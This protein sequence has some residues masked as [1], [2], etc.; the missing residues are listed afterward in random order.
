MTVDHPY[1]LQVKTLDVPAGQAGDRDLNQPV[2]PHSK[3]AQAA[4]RQNALLSEEDEAAFEEMQQERRDRTCEQES[5]DHYW[6]AETNGSSCD[7]CFAR[8]DEWST[9]TD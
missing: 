3:W 4:E 8:F 7:R 5:V 1:D 2:D 9:R 6:P